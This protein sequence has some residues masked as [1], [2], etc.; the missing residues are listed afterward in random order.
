MPTCAEITVLRLQEAGAVQFL[1]RSTELGQSF[2]DAIQA[3]QGILGVQKVHYSLS[4]ERPDELWLLVDW[5]SDEF[6]Q[7]ELYVL[8]YTQLDVIEMTFSNNE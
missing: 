8:S 1:D 6:C 7:N 4:I 5:E 2:F 3:I